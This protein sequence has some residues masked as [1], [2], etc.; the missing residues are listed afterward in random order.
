MQIVNIVCSGVISMVIG[1]L[2][3]VFYNDA[4]VKEYFRAVECRRMCR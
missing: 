4:K 2:S 3:L 1:I